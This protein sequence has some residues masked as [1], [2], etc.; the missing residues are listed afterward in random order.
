MEFKFSKAGTVTEIRD[1]LNDELAKLPQPETQG[2]KVIRMI[3]HY[4]VADHLDKLHD[5]WQVDVQKARGIGFA[6]PPEPTT[7][8]EIDC[9]VAWD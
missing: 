2:N 8:L 5:P 7:K 6:L 9:T 3:A 1:A 4:A